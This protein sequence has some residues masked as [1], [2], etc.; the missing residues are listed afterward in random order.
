MPQAFQPIDC[1]RLTAIG[2]TFFQSRPSTS[3]SNC[4]LQRGRPNPGPAELRVLKRLGKQTHPRAIKP[5][6]FD[7]V[8][9]FRAEHV[10]RAIERVSATIP[11]SAIKPVAP[12]RKSTGMLAT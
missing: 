5:D 3:A 12:L 11:T 4:A 9:S 10:E 7:P 8:R 2:R 1:G 6:R